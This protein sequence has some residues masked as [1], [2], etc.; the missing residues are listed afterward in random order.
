M[1]EKKQY[2][3]HSGSGEVIHIPLQ[4]QSTNDTEF[5][6]MLAHENA[7]T[8]EY[9]DGSSDVK[10]NK[11]VVVGQSSTEQTVS[12]KNTLVDSLP[13]SSN[14]AGSSVLEGSTQQTF[15]LQILHQLAVLGS[16]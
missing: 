16:S 11:E 8:D 6:G 13:D 12:S 5:L 10:Q 1:A 14:A 15:N 7:N 9:S 4:I 3:L 2:F